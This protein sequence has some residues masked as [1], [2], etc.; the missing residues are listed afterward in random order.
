[1]IS[2]ALAAMAVADFCGVDLEAAAVSLEQFHGYKGRQQI[3]EAGG[4]R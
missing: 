3:Y 1:M 4:V 2:G